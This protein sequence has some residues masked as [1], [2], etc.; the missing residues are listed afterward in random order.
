MALCPTARKHRVLRENVCRCAFSPAFDEIFECRA[1]IDR[2][3]R[4][5]AFPE[6]RN[7][8]LV[9]YDL[10]RGVVLLHEVN[11]E[12][13]S[14]SQYVSEYVREMSLHDERHGTHYLDTLRA[15]FASDRNYELTADALSVHVN[16]VQYR[17]RRMQELFG[18]RLESSEIQFQMM[19]SLRILDLSLDG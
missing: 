3:R 8:R 17:I 14:L 4:L 6:L 9:E 5:L 16:T 1:W 12:G 18:L 2:L 7:T 15:Y 11:R 13:R 10:Y 19:L